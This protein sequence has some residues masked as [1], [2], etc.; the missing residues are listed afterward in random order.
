[1]TDPK[2]AIVIL[3]WNA[4]KETYECLKSLEGLVYR[5]FEVFLV[6]NDSK[7]G[8]FSNL[9]EDNERKK[10]HIAIHFL[11]SGSNLGFAGGNNVAIRKAYGLNFPYYW[12]LN[13]DTVI[14][15]NSLSYLVDELDKHPD[16]GIAG[17]KIYYYNSNIIWFAGGIVNT[18]TGNTRHIGLRE[19]DKGQYNARN[20][21]DYIS[22]CS[23]FFRRQLIDSIGFMKED[24]F[25]YFEETDWNLR[26]HNKGWKVIFVPESHVYHKVSL[27]SGGEKNP[28]PFVAFYDIRNAY[29]M[30]KRTQ[31]RS[32]ACISYCYKYFKAAKKIIKMFVCHQNQKG[33]RLIFIIKGLLG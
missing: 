18:F 16:V 6:D 3:N 2:V 28:S 11:Q 27:S 15:K 25:L 8:S 32:K 30:I 22:G 1:M 31:N 4:Y 12:M 5:N 9:Q 20:E 26:A 19:E 17:S 21:T 13:N 7:D 33:K 10:F 29:W 23:L 24:Y 14:D